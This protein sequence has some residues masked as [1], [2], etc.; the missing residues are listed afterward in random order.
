MTAD[1]K[2]VCGSLISFFRSLPN[3]LENLVSKMLFVN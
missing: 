1:A 2:V 3:A